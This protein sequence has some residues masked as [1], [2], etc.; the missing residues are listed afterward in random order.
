MSSL[1]YRLKAKIIETI[2]SI[3][4]KKNSIYLFSTF[5][6]KDNIHAIL[7][8]ILRNKINDEYVIFCDGP[9]FTNYSEN[10]VVKIT[11]GSLKSMT[12]FWTSKYVFYDIGIYGQIKGGK[13]Q[14]LV[15]TWHGTSLKR[16]EYFLEK[17]HRKG[18]PPLC[19][20][21]IAYSKFFQPIIEKAFGLDSDHVLITGEPRNDY[22]FEDEKKQI[23]Q[24]LGIDNKDKKIVIWMPTWR[25]NKERQDENDGAIYQLGIPL[26]DFE[27]LALLNDVCLKNNVVLIIKWHGLQESSSIDESDYPA[28]RFLTSEDVAKTNEPLYHLVGCCD[29]LITD[30][31][32][33]YVNYL[34]LNRPICFAYDDIDQ[35]KC[36]RGFMFDDVESIMPGDHVHDIEGII[37]FISNLGVDNKEERV[38]RER[39]NELL[40]AYSD[41]RNSFRL[42]QTLGLI[43]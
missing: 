5:L 16:I 27:G 33:I 8:E 11:H 6:Y 15:N 24:K 37:H 23:I 31:S 12:A 17:N 41:N 19:S 2:N 3:V 36:N 42:L 30:Y 40:N 43:E 18:M 25:Q 28:I 4:P 29:A 22:L 34:V 1:F 9:A 26:I 13:N 35:Y 14:F 7:D 20:Y 32:S 10:N 39:I 38:F 21:S